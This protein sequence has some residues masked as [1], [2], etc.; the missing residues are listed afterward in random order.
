MSA[1]SLCSTKGG[2]WER[3]E[4][5]RRVCR[6]ETKYS[7]WADSLTAWTTPLYYKGRDLYKPFVAGANFLFFFVLPDGSSGEEAWESR[8][9]R[10]ATSGCDFWH[11][12]ATF[13]SGDCV[14]RADANPSTVFFFD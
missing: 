11:D 12:R 14:T 1:G 5:I 7:A 4:R 9:Q 2:S 3:R 8:V 6:T 13:Y 10:T